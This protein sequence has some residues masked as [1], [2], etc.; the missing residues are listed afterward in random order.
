MS[1]PALSTT[2]KYAVLTETHGGLDFTFHYFLKWNGNEKN[3]KR[4]YEQLTS[5]DQCIYDDDSTFHLDI[6]NLVSETTTREMCKIDIG[7][8][9]YR[10]FDGTLKPIEFKFSKRDDEEERMEKINNLLYEC[11]ICDFIDHEDKFGRKDEDM[12]EHTLQ[13]EPEY[14]DEEEEVHDLKRRLDKLLD[15]KN[16][17][18]DQK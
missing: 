1:A 18:K 15:K 14:D 13:K 4:L 3:L 11:G 6:E 2:Y 17:L 7:P 5:V 10:K 8:Y 12:L 16:G 9:Y